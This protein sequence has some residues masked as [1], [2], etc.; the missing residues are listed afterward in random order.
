MKQWAGAVAAD[1]LHLRR[2]AR[3]EPGELCGAPLLRGR[4]LFPRAPELAAR[5]VEAG[6]AGPRQL[7]QRRGVLLD[8]PLRQGHS[9]HQLRGAGLP[10]ESRASLGPRWRRDSFAPAA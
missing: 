6:V 7:Q 1:R 2:Q 9:L 3:G 8:A 4:H 10:G 5:A